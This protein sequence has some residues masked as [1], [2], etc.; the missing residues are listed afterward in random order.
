MDPS[1]KRASCKPKKYQGAFAGLGVIFGFASS[2][3]GAC[4][5]ALI[6]IKKAVIA[7]KAMNSG[8]IKCGQVF[9]LSTGTETD[10]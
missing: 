4:N 2:K 5:I 1:K 8:S 9:T 6:N 7:I 3:S 10:F